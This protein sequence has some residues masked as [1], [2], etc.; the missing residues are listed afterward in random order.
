M[1]NRIDIIKTIAK[2]RALADKA[3]EAE[4][5]AAM[6]KADKMLTAYNVAEAELAMAEADGT[7]ELEIVH[8]TQYG[9]TK[10][11]RNRS[12][13]ISTMGAIA[14]FTQTKL[15]FRHDYEAIYWT[16]HKADVEM[17][18][19]LAQ[20]VY[21]AM[22]REYKRWAR[23]QQAVPRSAKAS[24]TGGMASRISE[25][26]DDM[27]RERQ[28]QQK[29]DIEEMGKKFNS[30]FENIAQ[31]DNDK[32]LLGMTNGYM[33][34]NLDQLNWLEGDFTVKLSN[35]IAGDGTGK[36]LDLD[37][38]WEKGFPVDLNSFT[39]NYNVNERL[40]YLA[41]TYQYKLEG[42][43]NEWSN[44]TDQT[45]ASFYKLKPGPYSFQ[46]RARVGDRLSANTASFLFWI[47]NPWYL[48]MYAYLIYLLIGI[49]GILGIN[50]L[51][52]SVYQKRQQQLVDETE[53]EM[54]FI[55][56][57]SEQELM[58][59]KNERLRT[60]IDS[61][62]KELA[63]TAMSIVK[64]NEFLIEIRDH[65]REVDGKKPFNPDL[66]VRS[67]NREIENEESWEM[68]RDAFENVD[69]DFI[70]ELLIMHPQLTP[71]DLKLCTYLRLNLSSKEIASLLNISVRSM[72]TKR[73]RLRKKL[74]LS[75]DTNLV[76]YIL[77]I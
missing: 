69:K 37:R 53:K 27:T 50:Y 25:R 63:V 70:K 29:K 66:I 62:N 55:R 17:A 3:G 49:F 76:E 8:E 52:R 48:S 9:A 35:V 65:L 41:V 5:M 13:S 26:L 4:A 42:D 74:D 14:R 6:K 34:L 36:F 23:K 51:Y 28:T 31:I 61:K 2:L 77:S 10:L 24:F 12:K 7:F 67:I 47:K 71:N 15:C 33:L 54:Q 45:S 57:Q 21:D 39:F 72:E 16:G 56:L 75:H 20:L 64:K 32:Y 30:E 19:F 43:H 22:E 60:E 1:T 11:G 46:V 59:E 68:L 44:W 38:E 18:K 40:K 58:K 73:Y